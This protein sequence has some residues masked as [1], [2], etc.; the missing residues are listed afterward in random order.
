MALRPLVL[1]KL[2]VSS[3]L[4]EANPGTVLSEAVR[5][6]VVL[7]AV[8]RCPVILK[9]N[10]VTHT[11]HGDELEKQVDRITNAMLS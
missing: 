8:Q 6:A 5:E 3:I 7:S 4:A 1:E 2:S 11:V 9:H 10:G